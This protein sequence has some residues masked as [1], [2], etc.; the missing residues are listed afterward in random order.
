MSERHCTETHKR[1]C[2]ALSD[3]AR[4]REANATYAR[5]QFTTEIPLPTIDN[6]VTT[7]V[8]VVRQPVDL[9]WQPANGWA[10]MSER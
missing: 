2:N 6:P 5:R 8:P 1:A 3:T 10:R 4:E 7:P 9:T